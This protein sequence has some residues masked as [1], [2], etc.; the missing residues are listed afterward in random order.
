MAQ[1][2]SHRSLVAAMMA[3]PRYLLTP[4]P[5]R[6]LAWAL[7]GGPLSAALLVGLAPALL[8]GFS[9]HLRSA[10][11]FPLLDL[12]CAR[13]SLIDEEAAQHVRD[14]VAQA[15]AE[16]RSPTVREMGY[17]LVTAVI[18]GPIGA[19]WAAFLAI[20]TTV[21]L[22]APWLVRPGEPI[23]V[24]WWDVD[25]PEE[26]WTA[27]AVGVGVL[28]LSAYAIG[29]Y[30]GAVAHLTS[31]ALTDPRV[32]QREV[33][34]L[35][36]SRTALVHAAGQERRRI[37]SDLHDR[38][39]HRLVALALTLGI[40]EDNHGDDATGRLAA[41]AHRQLDDTLA[42]LRS[43]L[44]GIQPRALDEHG[45]VAAVTDLIGP[46]PLPV[47]TDF[48]ATEVPH[49]LPVAIEHAAYRV[50]NEALTNVIK[51]SSATA[52][53]IAADRQADSWWLTVR[54]DGSGNAVIRPGRGL[55]TLAAG[56]TAVDGTL[57]IDSP[58]GG[59]TEIRMHCPTT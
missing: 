30:A 11:W 59:P 14:D 29:T 9:R 35:G 3:G 47:S 23:N 8:L 53:T 27:A 5:W 17:L 55:D 26:S 32:L 45:L 41:E 16:Q 52:V 13:L 15:R 10:L 40:A 18:T 25:S 34:R 39:Q 20:L 28:I 1:R 7:I 19:I 37:E 4:W 49:R 48:G 54:D 51:H 58:D 36:D 44:L 31:A 24:M 21:L 33:T 12:E 43:V 38:V 2:A 42:E 57:T 50:V 56:V 46:Y 22:M 6:A